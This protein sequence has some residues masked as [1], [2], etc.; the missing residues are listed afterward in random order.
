MEIQD[1]RN[2]K[3]EFYELEV[4]NVF[5]YE[6]NL[7]IKIPRIY[8]QKY[9]DVNCFDLSNERLDYYEND[10]IVTTLKCELIIKQ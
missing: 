5:E 2:R 4:G 8:D 7:Y 9:G 1:N 6:K 10:T 3:K